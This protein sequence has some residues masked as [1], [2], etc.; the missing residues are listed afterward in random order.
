MSEENSFVKKYLFQFLMAFCCILIGMGIQWIILSN[1]DSGNNVDLIKIHPA[2]ST[3]YKFINPLLGVEL[4]GDKESTKYNS[5][6]SQLRKYIN[7]QISSRRVD[8]VSIYFL[9][10]EQG[11]WFGVNENEDF[12]AASLFKVPV[13][14]AYYRT[15]GTDPNILLKKVYVNNVS[16]DYS[17][18]LEPT[19]IVPGSYTIDKLIE[20]MIV[21]SDNKAKDILL[22]AAEQN[23]GIDYKSL[24]NVFTYLGVFDNAEDKQKF[25]I[26]PRLYSLFFRVLY[27]STYLNKVMSEKALD[28]LSKTNF[29]DGLVSLLPKDTLVAHKFGSYVDKV[30]KKEELH[31]CGIIYYPSQPYFLCVMTRGDNAN[32]LKEVI[33]SISEKT[34]NYIQKESGE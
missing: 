10:M 17:S 5:L 29:N 7:G 28:L 12:N 19:V 22:T 15:A 32:N 31:D 18:T 1:K 16:G 25:V 8:N 27:N 9:D 11:N 34:Y 24:E 33:R 3:G 4:S 6:T 14:L 30:N 20:N 2:Q 23:F 26:S 13:M 21:Y